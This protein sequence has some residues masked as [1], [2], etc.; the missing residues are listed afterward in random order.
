MLSYL[1]DFALMKV[2]SSKFRKLFAELFAM[3]GIE[4][5]Q[6]GVQAHNSFR[7]G[8]P[9][10]EMLRDTYRKLKIDHPSMQ[11]QLLLAIKV[12]GMNDTIGP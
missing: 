12:K 3:H 2:Q 10:Q 4:V 9:Y 11:R 1:T 5:K 7:I 6:S 8:K